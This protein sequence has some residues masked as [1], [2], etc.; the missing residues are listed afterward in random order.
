MS[1]LDLR[2]S[3]F[4]AETGATEGKDMRPLAWGTPQRDLLENK[5]GLSWCVNPALSPGWAHSRHSAKACFSCFAHLP[6]YDS[7]NLSFVERRCGLEGSLDKPEPNTHFQK[8]TPWIN[9]AKN[10]NNNTYGAGPRQDSPH[11]IYTG[12]LQLHGRF[13][14]AGITLTVPRGGN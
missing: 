11:F 3:R 9:N 8:E 2:A 1:K 12:P 6:W 13:Y 10:S 14:A 5:P 4:A 7:E